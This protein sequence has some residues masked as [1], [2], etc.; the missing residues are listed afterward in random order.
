VDPAANPPGS[1]ALAL[2]VLDASGSMTERIKGETKIEIAK[3]A[4]CELVQSLPDDTR[5]GLVVYGH[6]KPNDCDDIELLIPPAKLDRAA[7]IAAV[8]AI[9]PKGLTPLSGALEFAARSMDF[10]KQPATV[11]LVSDGLETCGRDPCAT[12]AR[13]KAAGVHFFVH[14]V[15]FDLSPK[16]AKSIACIATATGGRFLQANDAASLKDSLYFAVAEATAAGPARTTTPPP[17]VITPVTIKAPSSVL[18]GGAFPVGWT[19]PDNAGDY[20]TIVPKGTPDAD[21]GNLAYTRQGSPLQVTS[22]LDP[23]EAELR[24]VAGRSHTVL[25]RAAIKVTAVDVTLAAPA[26]AVAGAPVAIIW[27]GPNNEG[28]FITIVPKGTE[29]SGYAHYMETS[30]GSPLDVTAPMAPGEAEIR[31]LSGQ[32]GHVLAR[33]AITVLPAEVTLAAR[34]EV[35]AGAAVE[36]TWKGPNNQD[37]YITIVAQALPD[38]S[39]GNIAYTLQGSPLQVTAPIGVGACEIRY[40]SGQGDT[41]LARRLLKV[42]AAQITLSAPSKAPLGAPVPVAWTGPNNQND[43]ITIVPKGTPDGTAG[44]FAWT[45]SGSPALV[46]PPDVPGHCEARYMSGQGDIVLARIDIEITGPGASP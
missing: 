4:V 6:R 1:T 3:R 44:H 23:G 42:I 38:G 18:A 25:A 43:Y 26:E 14:T 40:M 7:F 31:Y 30:H 27:K 32:R 21:D 41:V 9:R 37:D 33:R 10:Q 28:D 5:L 20:I 15:G 45:L 35:A 22:L 24:Y 11:I 12:A 29:D 19:G 8:K 36:I 16:E 39:R 46:D 17:E 13:L 34:D 2:I